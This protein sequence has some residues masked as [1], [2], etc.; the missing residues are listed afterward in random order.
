M[1]SCICKFPYTNSLPNFSHY[2]YRRGQA[3]FTCTRFVAVA[4]PWTA[5]LE[6][7]IY[8][9]ECILVRRT[10]SGGDLIAHFFMTC[11]E[12]VYK[13]ALGSKF[14]SDEDNRKLFGKCTNRHGH[15][16]VG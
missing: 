7:R 14:L 12:A 5:V 15:N 10:N 4:L 3:Y 8:V 11:C 9:V 13:L 1:T 6:W 16:Y 2:L